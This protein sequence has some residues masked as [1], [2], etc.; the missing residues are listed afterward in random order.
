MRARWPRR[1]ARRRPRASCTWPPRSPRSAAPIACARSTSRACAG[2]WSVR[3]GRRAKVVFTSTVVTGEAHG[4]LL[5]EDEPLPVQTPYGRSKQEGEALLLRL[6]PAGG[7]RAPRPRLRAGRLVRARD[8]RAPAPARA[9]RGDRPRRQPVGRHPRRRR[10]ARPGRRARARPGGRDL[11]RGRRRA[12]RLLRLHGPQRAGARRRAAAPDPG[13]GR[14]PGRRL[15]RGDR[16]GA[17]RA[18]LQRKLKRELGWAP[19]Y[20]SAREGVPATVA[21]LRAGR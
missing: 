4:A 21:A 12:D 11:P 9:L 8:P 18:H 3:R 5:T 2:C 20:P 17:Q 13:L 19:R 15:E 14:P 10:R 7:R 1:C 6:R 16:R